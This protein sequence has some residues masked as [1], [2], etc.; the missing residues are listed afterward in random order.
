MSSRPIFSPD[1]TRVVSASYDGTLRLWD[2]AGGEP[3]SV[4]QGHAGE[5]WACAY[6]PD[7]AWLASAS[8]DHT[9]RLWD[10]ALVERNGALRGHESFVYDV[11]FSPDGV[12]IGSA[13]WDNSVR[14]WDLTTGRQTAL[15]K[16]PGRRD[17][18]QRRSDQDPVPYDPGAYLLALAFSPDGSQL[19]AGSRDSKVQFWDVKAGRLR[20]H[21]AASRPW[22]RLAGVQSQTASAWPRRSE[23]SIQGLNGDCRVHLLDARRGETLRTLTGHTDGVLAVRFAPDGRRTRLRGL[24]QD[25]P[26]LGCRH[27]RR[28]RRPDRPWRYR[29]RRRLQPGRPSPRLRIP[30]PHGPALG[31]PHAPARSTRCRTRASCM[32]S[33]SARTARVWLPAARTIR[34]ACGTWPHATKWPNCTA[35]RPTSMPSPSPR[36]ALA[37]CRHP[38]TSRSGSGIPSHPWMHPG[39]HRAERGDDRPG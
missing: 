33:P 39:S 9:V 15:F 13:A 4:L 27:R 32:R 17:P 35:T 5:V 1:G 8:A 3:I 36:M 21:G 37:W 20:A 7:G 14:L 25:R 11:A 28:A 12:H 23:I 19:V 24:R 22:R 30:R 29:D 31:R 16:G 38:A 26:R 6:S 18:G 10:T 34:F 2:P